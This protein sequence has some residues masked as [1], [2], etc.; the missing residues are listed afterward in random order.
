MTNARYSRQIILP[1]IGSDGQ[2]KIAKAKVLVIG[3]GGLGCPVIQYLA[4]AGIGKLGIIDHDSVDETNLAR[5]PLYSSSDIGKQKSIIAAEK[6]RQLNPEI[7]THHWTEKLTRDNAAL[8][9]SD[10]DI[11]ADCSDNFATRYIVNDTCVALAKPWVFAAIEG[12][13]G[14][15]SVFNYKGGPVYR[16]IFPD[17]PDN[18]DDCNTI[19]VIATLPAV[20]GSLQAN[21]ILKCILGMEGVLSGRLMFMDLLRQQTNYLNFGRSKTTQAFDLEISKEDLKSRSF[22]IIDIR[23]EEDIVEP[24]GFDQKAYYELSS[25]DFSL[26]KEYVLIC[27]TGRKSRIVAEKL[28]RGN[29]GLKVYSLKGGVGEIMNLNSKF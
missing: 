1:E 27:E 9:I 6:A 8:I 26:S 19:G 10:Y 23:P 13:E 5:Q 11:V 2:Q 18:A 29:P 24:L 25:N 28:R 14:Q 4:S 21:E 15:L 22:H 17:T 16:D 20:M 12:W 3:A 7:N